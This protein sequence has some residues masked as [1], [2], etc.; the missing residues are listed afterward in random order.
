MKIWCCCS[1]SSK[2][3]WHHMNNLLL[4]WF[5]IFKMTLSNVIFI[6]IRIFFSPKIRN[7]LKDPFKW[8]FTHFQNGPSYFGPFTYISQITFL[9][10]LFILNKLNSSLAIFLS[11]LALKFLNDFIL[12]AT[13]L[14]WT[15][16]Q[17]N[18]LIIN[19]K[20]LQFL[21]FSISFQNI[22]HL[23]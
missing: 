14:K 16:I 9:S 18:N 12:V 3:T 8:F 7:F 5:W 4:G 17:F 19:I 11:I 6:R 15:D 1:L 20:F 2:L 13:I 21:I 22:A 23:L 10:F